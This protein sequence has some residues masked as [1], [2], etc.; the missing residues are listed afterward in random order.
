MDSEFLKR[1]QSTQHS[2]QAEAGV[3]QIAKAVSLYYDRLVKS[4][5]PESVAGNLAS[6][7]QQQVFEMARRQQG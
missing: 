4:G 6:Q 2:D 7:F 1:L 5:V 3:K